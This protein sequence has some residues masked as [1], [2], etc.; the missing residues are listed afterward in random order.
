MALQGEDMCARLIEAAKKHPP[1]FFD[2][3]TV[4][5]AREKLSKMKC[6]VGYP[7]FILEDQKLDQFYEKVSENFQQVGV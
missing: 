5:K 3:E 2:R 4:E 1:H 7:S 6:A